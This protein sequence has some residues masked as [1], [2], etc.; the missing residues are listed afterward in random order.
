[1]DLAIPTTLQHP[2]DT[3]DVDITS[4]LNGVDYDDT[5]LFDITEFFNESS[6][7]SNDEIG[8]CE[9]IVRTNSAIEAVFSLAQHSECSDGAAET[10][11]EMASVM[12]FGDLYEFQLS[13][14]AA[15]GSPSYRGSPKTPE[16]G[17]QVGRQAPTE[18]PPACGRTSPTASDQ[19]RCQSDLSTE[20]G[21]PPTAPQD[22]DIIDLTQEND[23]EDR[24]RPPLPS[25]SIG[26]TKRK[27]CTRADATARKRRRKSAPQVPEE[28]QEVFLR[29]VSLLC[30]LDGETKKLTWN[31]RAKVWRSAESTILRDKVTL[32]SVVEVT[33]RSGDFQ[34]ELLLIPT[35]D[36]TQFIGTEME[37]WA[38]LVSLE[39]MRAMI[40][41]P[42]Q[43]T[44]IRT[45][46][47]GSATND[48]TSK[49]KKDMGDRPPKLATW[50]TWNKPKLNPGQN[51]EVSETTASMNDLVAN[52][53]LKEPLPSQSPQGGEPPLRLVS[54]LVCRDG[55]AKKLEFT[56]NE[57]E[58]I[59]KSID[60][61]TV[62]SSEA[63]KMMILDPTGHFAGSRTQ[64]TSPVINDGGMLSLEPKMSH[65]SNVVKAR[66]DKGPK[67]ASPD[68]PVLSKEERLQVRE[69]TNALTLLTSS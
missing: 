27:G 35:P 46:S 14:A 62:L 61:T 59:W 64:S 26:V 25:N 53:F 67:I 44:G 56:W 69:I 38:I 33:A 68:Q 30:H 58:G 66:V 40:L 5:E 15:T 52:L 12:G 45:Q 39:A 48:T 29:L 32:D 22:I 1:M 4:W 36:K 47:S 63:L 23:T 19:D 21:S 31:K 41:D 65:T 42:G 2:I 18:S 13:N 17:G 49:V 54:L 16:V 60:S 51:I 50:E 43:F 57:H 6:F 7:D 9:G 37:D 8:A 20:L 34:Y 11:V 24:D 3:G 55:E 28:G 10:P